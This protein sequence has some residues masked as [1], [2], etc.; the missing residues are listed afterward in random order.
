M[1]GIRLARLEH[2]LAVVL[3]LAVAACTTMPASAPQTAGAATAAAPL[4][5]FIGSWALDLSKPEGGQTVT[6]SEL[7]ISRL[8][9]GKLQIVTFVVRSDFTSMSS[10]VAFALDGNDNPVTGNRDVDASSFTSPDPNTLVIKE[11]KAGKLVDEV[12]IVVSPDGKTLTGTISGTGPDGKPTEIIKTWHK[13]ENKAAAPSSGSRAADQ[14]I[15]ADHPGP[16]PA[17]TSTP[18]STIEIPVTGA[19]YNLKTLATVRL[20]YATDRRHAVTEGRIN[21]GTTRE[22]PLQYG[23]VEVTIPPNHK[24]GNIEKPFILSVA[25]F[26]IY[27]EPEDPAKHFILLAPQPLTAEQFKARISGAPKKR[28]LIYIHGFGTSFKNAALTTAQLAYDIKFDGTPI[29]FS[30]P[31]LGSVDPRAYN[32][33]GDA[34]RTAEIDLK[35]LLTNVRSSV[36][37]DGEIYLIAHSM[38][39]VP[40]LDFLYDADKAAV[41]NL[42]AN[43]IV[44]AAPDVDRDYFLSRIETLTQKHERMTLYASSKDKALLI[45]SS[46]L[47]EGPPRAGLV[48]DGGLPAIIRAGID[49]IDVSALSTDIFDVAHGTYAQSAVLLDDLG[50]LFGSPNY[51]PPDKRNPNMRAVALP[52]G[53]FWRIQPY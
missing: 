24:R 25:S 12:V 33:D 29:F 40:L 21:Y 11:K 14:P 39:N 6:K 49:T 2:A 31:S 3:L 44:F 26:D 27:E 17:A 34:A 37:A 53:T 35:E 36:G 43:E 7:R 1:R 15:A 45:S 22:S 51:T 20:L 28:A 52:E 38:G 32:T 16:P 13:N 10:R 18:E 42:L 48:L 8:P 46:V 9:G 4:A 47:R 30:W 5:K 41:P 23:A 50:K 19:T